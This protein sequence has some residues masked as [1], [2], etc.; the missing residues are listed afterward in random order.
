MGKP[1]LKGRSSSAANATEWVQICEACKGVIDRAFGAGDIQRFAIAVGAST[2]TLGRMLDDYASG[3]WDGQRIVAMRQWEEREYRTGEIRR[4][5]AG[6][7]VAIP[8]GHS[9]DDDAGGRFAINSATGIVTVADG[10]LLDRESA[11]SHNIT[12]RGASADGSFSTQTF[13]IGI[14]DVD[15][16]DVGAVTDSDAG[17]NSVDENAA[18]GATVGIT[19]AASDADATANA[20]V[21]S[22]DDDAGGRCHGFDSCRGS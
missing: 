6:A 9:L 13:A 4:A 16:F 3:S 15:E 5:M 18:N 21:Y 10:S 7:P 2:D 12:V 20:V 1:Y 8:R 17:A 19:A 11:A 22:L 14:N